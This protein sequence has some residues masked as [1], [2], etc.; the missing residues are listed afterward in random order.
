MPTSLDNLRAAVKRAQSDL[1]VSSEDYKRRLLASGSIPDAI[2]RQLNEADPTLGQLRTAHAD[3][4]KRLGTVFADTTPELSGV[5]D[6][7]VREAIRARIS[8]ELGAEGSALAGKIDDVGGSFDRR[9][10]SL[11]NV[12]SAQTAAR[13]FDVSSKQDALTRLLGQQGAEEDRAFQSRMDDLDRQ[14]KTAEIA[15]TNRSNRGS[16]PASV[17]FEDAVKNPLLAFLAAGG[18]RVQDEAGGYQFFGPDGKPITVDE[19]AAMTPG[20]TR[21]HFLADSKNPADAAYSGAKPLSAEASKVLTNAQSGLSSLG[22]LE[23]LFTKGAGVRFLARLPFGLGNPDAQQ[24][25]NATRNIYDVIARLRTGAA[26]TKSEEDLYRKFVPGATDTPESARQKIER[27]RQIFTS[28]STRQGPNTPDI[29][30]LTGGVIDTG[31]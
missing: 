1:D 13:Q 12:Y 6:P 5:N 9:V 18:K 22:E 8:S 3:I 27:L 23:S 29:A 21:S 16:G 7:R 30:N 17:T 26:I 14:L 28:L 24:Y 31:I 25:Q 19:A 4:Q 20:G 11:G 15:A 10:E 2:R